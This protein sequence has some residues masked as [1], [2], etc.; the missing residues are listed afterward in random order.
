[1]LRDILA[2]AWLILIPLLLC[3][4]FACCIAEYAIRHYK[5]KKKANPLKYPNPLKYRSVTVH[6]K[7]KLNKVS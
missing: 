3:F 7:K 1:M 4:A 2:T 5:P 6:K